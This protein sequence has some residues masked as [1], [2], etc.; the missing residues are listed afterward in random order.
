VIVVVIIEVGWQ[1]YYYYYYHHHRYYYYYYCNNHYHYGVQKGKLMV[2]KLVLD[3]CLPVCFI[4][5][6]IHSLKTF[7]LLELPLLSLYFVLSLH[8]RHSFP[9]LIQYLLIS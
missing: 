7:F 6:N 8:V 2:S 3:C 1:H 4:T 9:P 5:D